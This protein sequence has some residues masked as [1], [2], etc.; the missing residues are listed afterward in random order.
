MPTVVELD[1]IYDRD[2]NKSLIKFS[3]SMTA[4][5]WTSTVGINKSTENWTVNFNEGIHAYAGAI[6]GAENNNP[7]HKSFVRC[8][9]E[10]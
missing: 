3:N 9:K 5:F 6:A 4:G 8:V 10:K 2:Q 7:D 1:S